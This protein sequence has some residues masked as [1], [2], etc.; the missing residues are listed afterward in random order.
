[1]VARA[2]CKPADWTPRELPP[3]LERGKGAPSSS[4]CARPGCAESTRPDQAGPGG[5][6]LERACTDSPEVTAGPAPAPVV[7][8]GVEL[9]V[10]STT[11]AGKS[12]R[13][14]AGNRCAFGLRLAD[15]SGTAVELG[16]EHVPAFNTITAV[17]R[18]GSAVWLSVGFNGYTKEFPGGGNR[19]I[20]VDL[21]AGRVVWQSKDAMSNGGL[22][23]LDDYLISPFGFTSERRFVYVLDARS[24]SVLQ[25][26]PVIENVCPSKSWAPNWHP[27]ERCDAPGQA[28]GAATQPRVEDG[29]FYVDTNTG[30][31]AF[32]FKATSR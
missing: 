7:V 13:N 12:G 21:C 23:L 18:S 20:A 14:W 2:E 6:L 30:S 17:V 16:P 19:V 22:L 25:K 24:G 8:D 27:G 1:M 3:L 15:G 4:A 5:A 26:L 28:V 32:H 9:R 10:L 11:P 31:S 29:L